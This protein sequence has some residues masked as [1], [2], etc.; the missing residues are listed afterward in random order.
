MWRR[1]RLGLLALSIAAF[2]CAARPV[3][4]AAP[5]WV[6][7]AAAKPPGQYPADT[8]AVVLLDEESLTV[9]GP[10]QA[11]VVHRRVVRILRPQGREEAHFGTYL[12]P[13]EKIQSLHAWSIDSAG[14]QY[15]IK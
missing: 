1:T 6:Q 12:A 5:D 7:Q 11:E 3:V 8:N 14:H 9:T 4:A 15:E 13:G 10:G 2:L